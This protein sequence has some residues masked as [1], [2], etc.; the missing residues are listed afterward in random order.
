MFDSGNM[1]KVHRNSFDHYSIWTANDAEGTQ[2][3]GYPKSWFYF[4]VGGFKDRRIIFSIHRLHFLW[5]LVKLTITLDSQKSF[6]SSSL[7]LKNP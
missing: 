1:K 6:V 2:N 7:P 3:E 5:A 4:R